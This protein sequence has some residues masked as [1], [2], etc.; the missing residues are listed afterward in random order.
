MACVAAVVQV[1]SLAWE[2]PE[3]PGAAGKK[4]KKKRQDCLFDTS[5]GP[6]NTVGQGI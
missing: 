6:N 3:V 2:L 1:Q 4:K 5:G